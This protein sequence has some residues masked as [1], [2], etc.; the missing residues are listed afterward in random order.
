MRSRTGSAWE[1]ERVA[2]VRANSLEGD[3]RTRSLLEG[4]IRI[5]KPDTVGKLL[6][7]LLLSSARIRNQRA[8]PSNN[9]K[10]GERK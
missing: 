1:L 3:A 6:W 7:C 8:S 10:A 2:L 5:T 4:T 9:E